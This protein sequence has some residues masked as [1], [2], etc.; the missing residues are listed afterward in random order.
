MFKHLTH[1]I[2]HDYFGLTDL[3]NLNILDWLK[4]SRL[5]FETKDN[6]IQT[7]REIVA[8][9]ENRRLDEIQKQREIGKRTYHK[10]L[11]VIGSAVIAAVACLLIH[12]LMIIFLR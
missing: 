8:F 5:F 4:F 7:Y 10:F 3:F 12:L 6:D 11:L 1:A 2:T 9:S